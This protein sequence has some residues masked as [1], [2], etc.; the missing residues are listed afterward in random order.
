MNRH[1]TVCLCLL[2]I[3]LVATSPARAAP[4]RVERLS[5]DVY[6]VCDD[7][8]QWG[9]SAT[10]MTH[11]RGPHYEA[12]KVLDL[13][14]V[15]QDVWAAASQVRLSA[16]FCV[17]DYSMHD[18]PKPNGLDEAFEIVVNGKPHRVPN[19]SGVPVYQ[20]GKPLDA[21]FA[22]HAFILPKEWFVWGPNVL[23]FHLVAP[24][25]KKADDY[26]YLGIDNSVPGG[27]S[28]GKLSKTDAWH[29]D[30]LNANNAKGEYM[31]RLYL[32]L[33]QQTF[34]V[35]WQPEQPRPVDPQGVVQYAGSHGGATRLEWDAKRLDRL[36]PLTLIVE[37]GDAKPFTLN[38]L[39]DQGEPVKPPLKAQGPRFETRLEPPLKFV[40]VGV[41]LDKQVAVKRI[42]LAASR[43]PH[44]A[45]RQVDMTPRVQGPQGARQN[46]KPSCEVTADKIT[47][48]NDNLC[49]QFAVVDGK[50]KLTSLRNE[51]AATDMVRDADDSA[52]VLV[53]VDGKRYAGSRD[54]VCRSAT[55]MSD[56][57]GFR[58][59]LF[60]EPH[61][62]EGVLTVWID[63][64]LRMG[65]EV[66]N[67]R[68]KPVDFKLAFPHLSGL[69]VSQE[70]ADD[71][72]FFPWG[73]GIFS[74]SPAVIRR[75]YGDHEA[76]YQV[77]DLFSPQRGAGLAV[78][79]T[80]DDGRH[81]VLALR[82]HIPGRQELNG[83]VVG[84]PTAKEYVW[85]NCLE[86]VPGTGMTYEYLRRTR[87][88]GESFAAKD[89]ALLAHAGDWHAAMKTYADWCHRVWTF[90]PYPSRLGPVL[91]M[92]AVGWGKSPIFAKGQ[93]RTDYV[94]PQSDC[95]ELMSWWEWSPLGPFSTPFDQLEQK[96]GEATSKRWASYFLNDPVTGQMMFNN[97]P[98]DYDG[99][100][101]RWGGLPAFREAVKRYQKMGVLT[102]LYTDPLRVDDN[103]K[104]GR[105]KGKQ[106]NIVKPDGKLQTNY[107]AWNPCLDVAE[108]RQWVA[109]AM[110][111]VMRETGVDGIRLDEYGHRGSACFSKLHEHT[112]AEWGTTEWQ[113]CIAESTRL[114]RQAMDAVKPDSVLT[115]EHP[116]YDYLMPVMDGCITYDLTVQATPLRPLECNLQRFYFPECKCYELDH[117]H[118]DPKHRKRFWN[119]VSSFGA[120]YPA[121]MYTIIRENDDAFSSRDCE[122]LVPT[123]VPHVYANRFHGGEK[124]IYTLYNATGHTFYGP[125]LRLDVQP[126]EHVVELLSGREVERTATAEGS[127]VSLYLERDNVACLVKLPI[128]MTVKRAGNVVDVT[129]RDPNPAW[130]VTLCDADGQP[131]VSRPAGNGSVQLNLAEQPKGAKPAVC[132]KLLDGKRLVDVTEATEK[133]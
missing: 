92:I 14:K 76:I 3:A 6:L 51:L 20:D 72:Y 2:I 37:T 65:F 39:D 124:T 62:L 105:L 91:N 27:N 106:L 34:Q 67:R 78:W 46:R 66:T 93:Y 97:N 64:A 120:Y 38:W 10:G 41:A 43:S 17:R 115:T 73:G 50:L 48:A 1:L 44:P 117:R 59:T 54:F 87:K 30:R 127:V 24:E 33:G 69:A 18:A 8:G 68:D 133:R 26:L 16:Y 132:V 52:L 28:W 84:T 22:W 57:Q 15:P 85:T 7:A 102:T 88:P 31:V 108:Y 94:K 23:V 100:N 96:L 9:G 13:G 49:C 81:K 35:S 32:L 70:P 126:G 60:S 63:D 107:E 61:G 5:D 12:K 103:T 95:L 121:N 111:R 21:G 129:V 53:E 130:Q 113:R 71:Y 131:L 104:Y 11:Q 98:G 128:R 119:A 25:G 29:A 114:V 42:T 79:C 80:D 45:T 77:M 89:V 36:S 74:D 116:G 118:A 47:L 75:G 123:L 110:A 112:F 122:P 58:A 82:K 99:Y 19:A 4:S 40:P 109:K 101:Q 56:R 90:R 86:A 55:P 125:A 83:D